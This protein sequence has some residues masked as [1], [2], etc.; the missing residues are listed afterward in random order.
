[1]V[2]V[3]WLSETADVRLPDTATSWIFKP[4]FVLAVAIFSHHEL[5]NLA[6]VEVHWQSIKGF[7]PSHITITP[8]RDGDAG[9]ASDLKVRG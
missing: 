3:I 7:G 1:M 6:K 8:S 2:G 5:S 4:R 9:E